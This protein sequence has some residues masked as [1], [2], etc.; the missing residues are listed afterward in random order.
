MQQCLQAVNFF[1]YDMYRKLLLQLSGN[2]N[3]PNRAERFAAGALA[4]I[5]YPLAIEHHLQTACRI[6]YPYR[7]MPMLMQDNNM[8]DTHLHHSHLYNI[9]FCFLKTAHYTA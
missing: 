2:E 8:H 7:A 5:A 1:S 9:W 3:K 4:G 6:A